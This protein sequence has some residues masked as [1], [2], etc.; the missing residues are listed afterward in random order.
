MIKDIGIEGLAVDTSGFVDRANEQTVTLKAMSKYPEKIGQASKM[1]PGYYLYGLCC[2]LIN[3]QA[4][5]TPDY[6]ITESTG[7]R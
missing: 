7:P 3:G 1:Y 2:D 4:K 5:V 6:R